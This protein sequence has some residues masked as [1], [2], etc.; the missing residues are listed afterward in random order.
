MSIFDLEKIARNKAI[1]DAMPN[2]KR[3]EPINGRRLS[4]VGKLR[5]VNTQLLE[6]L[7][8]WQRL[9]NDCN[10]Q[11]SSHRSEKERGEVLEMTK[12]AIQ[13]AEEQGCQS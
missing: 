9:W 7:K 8:G 11:S 2:W 5:A 3:G 4:E 12:A 13:A 10:F 6:A 1:V